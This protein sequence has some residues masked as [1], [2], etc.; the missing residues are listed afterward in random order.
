MGKYINNINETYM[1][2]SF[3]D[4]CKVLES[5][6]ALRVTGREYDPNLVCVVDNGFFA[7]AAW[8]YS[9]SE[10]EQFKKPDGRNKSWYIL[11]N[12]ESHVDTD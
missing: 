7:A 5:K 2:A 11:S 3:A 9:E 1:G 4:K 8:A 10:W 6:G 12:A